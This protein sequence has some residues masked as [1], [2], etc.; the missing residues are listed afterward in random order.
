MVW[1]K[2]VSVGISS[3]VHIYTVVHSYGRIMWKAYRILTVPNEKLRK[4]LSE[5]KKLLAVVCASQRLTRKTPRCEITVKE[6]KQSERK[7]NVNQIRSDCHWFNV[8][9]I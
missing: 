1:F 3:T 7:K 6:E 4:R 8:L 9:M 2:M 5:F